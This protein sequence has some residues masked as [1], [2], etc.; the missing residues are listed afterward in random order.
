MKNRFER[1]IKDSNNKFTN[2]R[3]NNI[4]RKFA[5]SVHSFMGLLDSKKNVFEAIDKDEDEEDEEEDDEYK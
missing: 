3:P 1:M 4:D 2:D 5:T